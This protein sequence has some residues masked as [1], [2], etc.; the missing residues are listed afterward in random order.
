M[1]G[2]GELLFDPSKLEEIEGESEDD[3]QEPVGKNGVCPAHYRCVQSIALF[4]M[5]VGNFDKNF[6]EGFPFS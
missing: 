3:D 6:V 4:T 5:V 1:S 2:F